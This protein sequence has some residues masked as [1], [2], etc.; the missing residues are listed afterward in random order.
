MVSQTSMFCKHVLRI[1]FFKETAWDVK[2]FKSS[3]CKIALGL[4]FF[5]KQCM[6]ALGIIQ[7][8]VEGSNWAMT[9]KK[10]AWKQPSFE[11]SIIA[12]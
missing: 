12:H 2:D 7:S 10:W 6:H 11:E 5:W 8:N 9:T 1:V 4:N 3:D